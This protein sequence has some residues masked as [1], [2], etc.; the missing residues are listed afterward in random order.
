MFLEASLWSFLVDCNISIVPSFF[1]SL[2]LP[3]Q[4][5]PGENYRKNSLFFLSFFG[6]YKSEQEI[7]QQTFFE[8]EKK[9]EKQWIFSFFGLLISPAFLS[10]S[11]PFSILFSS[12][13]NRIK[14]PLSLLVESNLSYFVS[15]NGRKQ[16]ESTQGRKETFH[17]SVFWFCANL[18][19]AF[20]RSG[21]TSS[22]TSFI[23]FSRANKSGKLKAEC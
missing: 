22:P 13:Y 21:S 19:L 2:S 1:L 9:R 7:G 17:S 23:P 6:P 18:W 8:I 4:L 15:H 14:R 12:C 3:L 11:S 20:D 5:S 10:H 16:K